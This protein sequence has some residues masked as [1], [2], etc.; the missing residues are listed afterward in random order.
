MRTNRIL[1]IGSLCGAHV[2]NLFDADAESVQMV[3]ERERL[4]F[5]QESAHPGERHRVVSR[6]VNSPRSRAGKRER[7]S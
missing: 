5:E 3:E 7:W 2:F 6:G 4:F 1:I